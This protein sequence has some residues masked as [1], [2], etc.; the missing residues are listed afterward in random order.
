MFILN[1]QKQKSAFSLL[2]VLISVLVLAGFISAVVQ[3]SYGNTRRMK[4]ARQL[5]KIANLLE[6]KM[7]ELEETFKGANIVNL[8]E[9]SEGDFPN[10][11]GYSWSYQTQPLALPQPT[12]LLSLLK[13]PENEINSKIA[14]TL[15][16]VFSDLVIELKLTVQHKDKK[17]PSYSLVSYF[18]NYAEAPDFIFNRVKGLLPEGAGI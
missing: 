12:L 14:Q 8:P 9:K 2:E 5:E 3:L 1:R 13:I 16:G 7:W 17:G 18:I 4:K 10:N 15:T 6:I 11:K